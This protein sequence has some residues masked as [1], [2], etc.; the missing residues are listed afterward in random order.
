MTLNGILKNIQKQETK[1][2]P[3]KWQLQ[4]LENND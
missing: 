4:N 1:D 2:I 3:N